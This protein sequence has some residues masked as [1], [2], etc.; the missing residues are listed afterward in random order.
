MMHLSKDA[1]IFGLSYLN[2]STRTLAFGGEGA[3]MRITDRARVALSELLAKRYAIPS[4][5]TDSI[6]GR[7]FYRGVDATPSL[8]MLAKAAGVDPF[9]RKSMD[10]PTFVRADDT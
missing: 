7:E 9:D 4:E 1:I 10:W 5:P 6:S 8:G 2:G 3:K